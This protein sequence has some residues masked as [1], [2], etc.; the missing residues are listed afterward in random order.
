MRFELWRN[1]LAHCSAICKNNWSSEISWKVPDMEFDSSK[2]QHDGLRS[3]LQRLGET[4]D[5]CEPDISAPE[6][7]RVAS[8]RRRAPDGD[9]QKD[10]FVPSLYEIPVKDGIDLMDIAVFRLSKRRTRKAD[11]IRHHLGDAIIEVRGGAGGMATIYDYDLV[12]MMVSHLVEQKRLHDFGRG[13]P[14]KRVFRP[15][16]SDIF[17]FCRLGDG[18]TNYERLEQALDRLQGTFIKISATRGNARRTGYFPLIAGATIVSRTDGGRIGVL[19]VKIPDWIYEGVV[20]HSKPEVL[21][22]NP[23]YFLIDRGLGRFIYR[24]A[25][26]AAGYGTA[27]YSVSLLRE[28]SGSEASPKEFARMVRE[29]VAANDLPDYAL[30]LEDGKDGQLLTMTRR[31]DASTPS[32]SATP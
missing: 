19:D 31:C 22:V 21:T 18:G 15:H 24:L 4:I 9:A 29:I 10:F 23:D 17:R 30:A 12:L 26:K 7:E 3:A 25:R 11:I 2:V 6:G 5:K 16:S 8:T 1:V 27:R 14:P 13:E 32:E 28:R 20:K